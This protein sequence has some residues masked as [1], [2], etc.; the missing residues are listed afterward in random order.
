MPA[1]FVARCV[2]QLSAIIRSNALRKLL[3]SGDFVLVNPGNGYVNAA[4]ELPHI[5]ASA[6]YILHAIRN[7]D[8][9]SSEVVPLATA[10]YGHPW[11]VW[12][13]QDNSVF[14]NSPEV[15]AI[16]SWR[17]AA[18][19]VVAAAGLIAAFG[20]FIV[21]R[22]F[23]KARVAKQKKKGCPPGTYLNPVGV[24]QLEYAIEFPIEVVWLRPIRIA[25]ARFE[26]DRACQR[27]VQNGLDLIRDVRQAYADL[28]LAHERLRV[29]GEGLRLRSRIAELAA[30]RLKAGDIS[31]LENATA[32]IDAQQAEQAL[33]RTRYDVAL[34]EER[35]RNLLSIGLCRQ[36]LVLEATRT[37]PRID[38]DAKALTTEALATR[39]DASAAH[40][41][42]EAATER[43]RLSR[44]SW[45]RFLGIIDANG[46]GLK[47]HEMGPGFRVTIPIF[48]W[49]QG[50]IAR[51]EAELERA[52]RQWQ[53][54]HDLIVL[55]VNR[56]LIQYQQARSE[57][58]YL[59]SKIYPE[60]EG[61]VT[62]ADRAFKEGNTT[63]LLALEA[64]RQLLDSHMR[65]AQLHADLRRAWAEL[66]RS[67]GR[68]LP[69]PAAVP[70]DVPELL[71]LP[72]PEPEPKE[73]AP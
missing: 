46:Q 23:D 35:L 61:A 60:L 25:S 5:K 10:D 15:R 48:N 70:M 3:P 12:F 34:A 2:I 33:V 43:L 44:L 13:G 14:H 20:W 40:A 9:I 50:G 24:K 65:A 67:V 73:P 6:A 36:P 62:R 28:L 21:Q 38:A 45:F 11:F 59:E 58:E 53:T 47:G 39:P 72:R 57:L 29:A 52:Q 51:A 31:V 17:L 30:A 56:A 69:A 54:L 42:V 16:H 41:A 63:Y 49:G 55:E 37:T 19:A 26:N 64:T 66:E 7:P 4:K 1:P 32:T 27:L 22:D 71:P 68:R 8:L 18:L